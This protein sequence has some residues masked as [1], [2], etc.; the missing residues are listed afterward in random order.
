LVFLRR[1][2]LTKPITALF[3]H[4]LSDAPAENTRARARDARI[5]V[6]GAFMSAKEKPQKTDD[7]A[8]KPAAAREEEDKIEIS[9]TPEQELEECR[10]QLAAE[11]EAKLRILAESENFK[12]RL[13]KEKEEFLRYASESVIADMLPVLDNIDLALTHG[14]G[15]AACKDLLMGV[16][17]TRKIFAEILARHG[18][19]EFGGIGEAFNPEFHEAIGVSVNKELPEEAVSQ[20]VQK[21]FRLRGRLVRPAKVMVN[22]A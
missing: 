20:V 13:A 22:K 7:L 9:L 19:E 11:S 17:M 14:R 21:G 18:L 10:H 15:N 16:D 5:T 6:Q 3:S 1:K 8:A 2:Q 4:D 12:K